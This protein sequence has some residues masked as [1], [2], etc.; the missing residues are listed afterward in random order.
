[1]STFGY[2]MVMPSVVMALA[3]GKLLNVAPLLMRHGTKRYLLHHV[4]LGLV[5]LLLIQF[6][7][8]TSQCCAPGNFPEYLLFFVF[9]AS[10]Y[11]A[12]AMLVPVSLTAK[13]I[14]FRKHYYD[15]AVSAYI[16]P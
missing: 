11:L 14:D 4:W 7:H 9:P 8:T 5:L 13:R 15:H 2:L 10:G 6:W 3:F 1:M 12:S 16:A